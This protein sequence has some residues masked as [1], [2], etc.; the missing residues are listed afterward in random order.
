MKANIKIRKLHLFNTKNYI[1]LNAYHVIK[2]TNLINQMKTL[3]II[4]IKMQDKYLIYKV[5]V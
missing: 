3:S 2:I 1:L 4:N 5:I